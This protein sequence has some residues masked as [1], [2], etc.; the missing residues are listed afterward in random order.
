MAL[1]TE[2]QKF[3][4]QIVDA[5]SPYPIKKIE[6]IKFPWSKNEIVVISPTD[7]FG[8]RIS[9]TSLHGLYD[10]ENPDR[11]IFPYLP[12]DPNVPGSLVSGNEEI[13]AQFGE[14]IS[15]KEKLSEAKQIYSHALYVEAQKGIDNSLVIKT[16][17]GGQVI[18]ENPAAAFSEHID[19]QIENINKVL[20]DTA[21][22]H[23]ENPQLKAA[24][25][26]VES[27]VTIANIDSNT[28]NTT[29]LLNKVKTAEM[30]GA[31]NTVYGISEIYICEEI[32][33]L[34][35]IFPE[36]PFDMIAKVVM[37]ELV[38]SNAANMEEKEDKIYAL[39]PFDP[40][41]SDILHHIKQYSDYLPHLDVLINPG[42]N[43]IRRR[44]LGR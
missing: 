22:S 37:L 25:Q 20:T 2:R 23:L 12:V 18:L 44:I 1:T 29:T 32:N 9:I 34:R 15:L 17:S 30:I 13:D 6:G 10:Q 43:K 7:K 27:I 21:N 31:G 40:T 41:A 35:L 3:E 39:L 5:V 24:Q 14:L 4:T 28:E 38:L 11:F 36:A 26:V 42:N 33:K 19:K 16:A 8:S